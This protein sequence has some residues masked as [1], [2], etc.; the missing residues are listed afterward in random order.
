MPAKLFEVLLEERMSDW[1]EASGIRASGQFGFRRQSGTAH[2]AL[3][4]STLQDQHRAEEQQLWACFV[5]FR[6]AY[7]SVP[8][9]RLWDKLAASGMGG[10]WLRAVQALYADVPMAQ[11]RAVRSWTLPLS[12]GSGGMVPPLLYADDTTLLAT[13]ADGLQR[14]LDLLQRNCE[15]WGLTVNAAKTKLVLLSGQR[16]QQAAVDIAQLAALSLA[17]QPL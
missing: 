11:R 7:D 2:A 5:E 6:K 9:Q 14:Q 8:R 16:T 3:I 12:R 4:L 13:T 15:Q 17:G 10:S 1:A